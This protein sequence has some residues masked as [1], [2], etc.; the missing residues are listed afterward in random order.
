MVG[1]IRSRRT[2]WLRTGSLLALML[3]L[4]SSLSWAATRKIEVW[5]YNEWSDWMTTEFT[6]KT[7]AKIEKKT[8]AAGDAQMVR[9]VAGETPD[10]IRIG[11]ELLGEFIVK[12]LVTDLTPYATRDKFPINDILAVDNVM[13]DG[14]LYGTLPLANVRGLRYNEELFYG[15]GLAT[16]DALIRQD[17]W[18]YDAFLNAAKRLTRDLDGDGQ[19]DQWGCTGKYGGLDL[20]NWLRSNGAE[21]IDESDV[22]RLNTPE[23]RE[24]MEFLVSLYREHRV[25]GSSSVTSG[26]TAMDDEWAGPHVKYPWLKFAVHPRGPYSQ[27]DGYTVVINSS[28]FVVYSGSKDK[29]MAWEFIKYVLSP[30]VQMR[31]VLASSAD[32]YAKPLRVSLLP[33]ALREA[34]VKHPD[35][36]WDL[37]YGA[38]QKYGRA[39]PNALNVGM[40]IQNVQTQLRNVI[41][42]DYP[43]SSFVEEMNDKYT[44]VVRGE[45]TL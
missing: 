7:G 12:G 33:K 14:R 25:T 35:F 43:V 31:G 2:C 40:V 27:P 34:Q 20:L 23:A 24:A 8:V 13:K 30:E 21:L 18:T 15:A 9:L 6:E 45:M 26:K 16:P 5:D 3:L 36:N 41:R 44:R 4:A 11:R 37:F 22:S 10:V 28:P 39:F 32:Q 29:D 19:P 38:Q 17:R 1:M 42:G